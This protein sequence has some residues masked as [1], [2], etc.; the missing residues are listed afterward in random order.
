MFVNVHMSTY[1]HMCRPTQEGKAKE[2]SL[3]EGMAGEKGTQHKCYNLMA[4]T[5]PPHPRAL[6]L[7]AML[8]KSCLDYPISQEREEGQR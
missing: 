8:A 1:T 5:T 7:T 3:G 2:G 6:G 4:S